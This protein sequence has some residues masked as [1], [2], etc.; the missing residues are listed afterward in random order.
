M[1]QFELAATLAGNRSSKHSF[2]LTTVESDTE[3]PRDLNPRAHGPPT[4]D[5]VILL[6]HSFPLSDLS[7]IVV[8]C[9]STGAAHAWFGA[10][11][12]PSVS[13]TLYGLA[14]AAL[15]RYTPTRAVHA[16]SHRYR[17]RIRV[18]GVS[19]SQRIVHHELL[20]GPERRAG[21]RIL[22]AKTASKERFGFGPATVIG[23]FESKKFRR[24]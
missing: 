21:S 20:Q 13:S 24:A 6:K 11:E 7:D 12:A 19:A 14:P 10:L 23:R 18:Y 4:C 22:G 17:T 3:A 5:Y 1:H 9:M 2:V 15:V 8:Y 16:T